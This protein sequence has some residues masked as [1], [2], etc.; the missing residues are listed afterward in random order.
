MSVPL[1]AKKILS[2]TF[3]SATSSMRRRVAAA[4]A[5]IMVVLCA[6]PVAAHAAGGLSVTALAFSPQRV[7][8]DSGGATSTLTFTI[9][10]ANTGATSIAGDIYIRQQGDD[11]GTYIGRA[12]DVQFAYLN[13]LSYDN[14]ADYVS[15]SV[16]SSSYT[17]TFPVPRYASKS[18]VKWVISEVDVQDGTGAGL[19]VTGS[20]LSQFDTAVT[21]SE[22]VDSTQPTYQDLSLTTNMGATRPYVYAHGTS[23]F[24]VYQFDVQDSQSGFWKGSIELSGPGGTVITTPFAYTQEPGQ[25]I[26][27]C[28]LVSGGTDQ[29]L[30]CDVL[31]AFP[32]G[33][34]AGTWTV[35]QLTLTDNA[36]NTKTYRDLNVLP[37]VVTSDAAVSAS[38]FTVS[39]AELNTWTQPQTTTLTFAVSGAQQ[40]ISAVYVDAD[41]PLCRQLS[42]TPTTNPDGTVSIPIQ[43]ST[44]IPDC[45]INGIAIFDGAGNLALYGNE[46]G[47]PDPGI[48]VSRVPDTTPPTI[49]SAT[50]SQTTISQTQISDGPD[51]QVIAQTVAPIAPIDGFS[52]VVYDSTGNPADGGTVG[53]SGGTGANADGVLDLN[54]PL[55]YGMAPGTYTVGFLSIT[56]AGNLTT[57]YGP[58]ANPIPGG[59]LTFTVTAS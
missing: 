57:A 27:D 34:A 32:A 25:Q 31:V 22:T 17:Y 56:D 7:A 15:G 43:M 8:A 48:T 13:T 45:D 5:L 42:T 55:P 37:V 52:L 35:S 12:Y 18:M 53:E 38:A 1:R 16:Q 39:P 2:A 36:N 9:A 6:V 29:D 40:G 20:S 58:G 49:T 14:G 28:G 19:S 47:A 4:A 33:T 23:G 21:A 30:F 41:T 26:F 44:F 11:P 24:Q 50:L 10:D 54:V 59:P 3:L 51:L 46:Y